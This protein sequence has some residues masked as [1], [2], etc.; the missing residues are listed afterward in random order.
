MK[1][2]KELTATQSIKLVKDYLKNK[3]LK[4]KRDSLK[5]GDFYICHYNAKDKEATYDKT[6]L[7]ILLKSNKSHILALNLHWA[8][9]PLRVILVKKILQLNSRNIKN[10]K[11]L[12]LDYSQIKPFLKRIG[13]APV[14]RLYIRNRVS[15]NVT[16]LPASDMMNIARLKSET[17]TQ[18]K[19]SAEQLYK[20][21]LSGNKKYRKTRK[22]RE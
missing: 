1:K 19:M 22:R 21:A 10:N 2:V 14:I 17:F 3:Q 11:P 16:L 13:F 12:E 7:N 8:P 6:P 15:S 5:P 20:K 18:G 4:K 9:I